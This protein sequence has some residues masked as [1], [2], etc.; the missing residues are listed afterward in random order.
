MAPRD[1][2]PGNETCHRRELEQEFV[3]FTITNQGG[4]KT[5]QAYQSRSNEGVERNLMVR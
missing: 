4:N 3:S 2:S 5:G 1:T